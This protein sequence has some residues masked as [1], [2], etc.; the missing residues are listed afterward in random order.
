MTKNVCNSRV[1]VLAP[2]CTFLLGIQTGA[3]FKHTVTVL[4][5]CRMPPARGPI[6]MVPV[7]QSLSLLSGPQPHI[8]PQIVVHTSLYARGPEEADCSQRDAWGSVPPSIHWEIND[9]VP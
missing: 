7:L 1:L 6:T 4:D 8:L 2:C 5:S 9:V 3:V